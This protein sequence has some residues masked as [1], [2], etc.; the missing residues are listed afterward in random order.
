MEHQ[1][2]PVGL[3]LPPESKID[4]CF[5]R[6]NNKVIDMEID[7]IVGKNVGKLDT[8][9]EKSTTLV[10]FMRTKYLVMRILINYIYLLVLASIILCNDS[11]SMSI[12]SIFFSY[13]CRV[14]FHLVD[15]LF[16]WN[17]KHFLWGFILPHETDID[18]GSEK[19]INRVIDMEI[20]MIVGESVGKLE[21]V[22]LKTTL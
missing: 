6:G 12:I 11:Q 7:M 5:E 2:L 19:G 3:I 10:Q 16:E 8:V 1:A 18:G 13:T 15:V 4:G 22:F 21:I 9:F 20:D 14:I 17:N